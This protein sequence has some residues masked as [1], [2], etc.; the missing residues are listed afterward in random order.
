MGE[1][2]EIP[3]DA[4]RIRVIIVNLSSL[5]RIL[6]P[7]LNQSN[8]APNARLP[9]TIPVKDSLTSD[10]MQEEVERVESPT[11]ELVYGQTNWVL[12]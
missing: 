5:P 7:L 4:V 2:E 11:S 1:G 6:L 3:D 12:T 9:R 8:A 10:S